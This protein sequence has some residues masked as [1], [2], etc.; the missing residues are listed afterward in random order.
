MPKGFANDQQGVFDR[1]KATVES[2]SADSRYNRLAKSEHGKIIS[3]DVARFLAPEFDT[4][5]GRLHHTPSTASPAGW[6]AHKRLLRE[7]VNKRSGPKHLSIT[8]GGAGSGKTHSLRS[9]TS[10]ATLVFENQFKDSARAHEVLT[11][12]LT[13]GWQVEV[14]YVHRPFADVVRAVIERSQRTGRWN[15]LADLPS[16]HIEAQR[17]VVALRKAFHHRGVTFQA[18]YNTSSSSGQK[19]PGDR[20]LFRD[21]DTGGR[22]HLA[23][24]EALKKEIPS[25]VE[26]T[27]K[28]GIVCREVASLICKGVGSKQWR[29]RLRKN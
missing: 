8:S 29:N 10:G 1:H 18:L 19:P 13:N 15:R 24:A 26:K 14:Q 28:D 12:A 2:S 20:V 4:W 21:L 6:Y 23:D 11:L 27:R 16:M 3:V 25:I 17:T 5:N 7:I 9:S 22:Y